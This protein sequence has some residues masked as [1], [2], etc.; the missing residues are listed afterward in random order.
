[1]AAA[2]RII[3]RFVISLAAII[4]GYR[5]FRQ[6]VVTVA[7]AV[8]AL[9][10]LRFVWKRRKNSIWR[11]TKVMGGE[12]LLN[13]LQQNQSMVES[14]KRKV[15]KVISSLRDL[16]ETE[17]HQ[18]ESPLHRSS[19][20]QEKEANLSALGDLSLQLTRGHQKLSES[21]QTYRALTSGLNNSNSPKPG[22]REEEM[23]EVIKNLERKLT[24]FCDDIE[25]LPME[26]PRT[27]AILKTLS[28]L[29]F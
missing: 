28:S 16:P 13:R 9:W 3:I 26:G 2:L 12:A 14:W 8:G 24:H 1:M 7:L 11:D 17:E 19:L 6:H 27:E 18:K 22:S 23:K 15:E 25:K 5:L 29:D 20:L 10:A 4:L 21:I